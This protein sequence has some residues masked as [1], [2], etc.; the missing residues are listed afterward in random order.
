MFFLFP[1][2]HLHA[3]NA[4]GSAMGLYIKALRVRD[5]GGAAAYSDYAVPSLPD[6][7]SAGGL[8]PGGKP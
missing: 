1:L 2:L 6:R 3:H 5:R 4:P 7:V 8:R